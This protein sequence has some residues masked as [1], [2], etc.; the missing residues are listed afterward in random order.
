[1]IDA[2]GMAKNTMP[3][4][5]ADKMKW[6]EQKVT[7]I[8]FLNSQTR[9]NG[10]PLNYVLCGNFNPIK[11]NNPNFL[12]DYTD[13]TPVQGEVFIHDA[14]KVH[15]YIIRL[16]SYNTVAEQKILPHQDNTNVR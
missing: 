7:L 4:T 5:F 9:R 3:K 6:F 14:A 10:V 11:R 12:D 15:S 16:I 13:R 1:M 8:N 2:E